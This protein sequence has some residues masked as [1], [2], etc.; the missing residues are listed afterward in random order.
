MKNESRTIA[1]L[2]ISTFTA[3]LSNPALAITY[4]VDRTVGSFGSVTGL[5]ETD[6]TLGTLGTSNIVDWDLDLTINAT[7]ENYTPSTGSVGFIS[8]FIDASPTELTWLRGGDTSGVMGFC[9]PTICGSVT[10]WTVFG[11]GIE[12]LIVSGEPTQENFF[13]MGT[14]EVIASV[15]PVPGAAWLFSSG[16]I[17]GI[18]YNRKRKAA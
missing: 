16:L 7:T 13:P 9:A 1:A 11:N 17:A 5:I 2:I 15:V 18:G 8:I 6:G 4:Q 12:R 10:Q 14:D 3:L